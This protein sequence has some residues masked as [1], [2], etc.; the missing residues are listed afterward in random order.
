MRQATEERR[1]RLLT[2]EGEEPK[3]LR[4]PGTVALRGPGTVA[5]RGAYRG[6]LLS[7]KGT[8]LVCRSSS[9]RPPNRTTLVCFPL[10]SSYYLVITS[11][12]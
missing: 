1:L 12:G 4:G 7:N 11:I 8:P 2:T 6:V 10:G 5:L 9:P 3:A